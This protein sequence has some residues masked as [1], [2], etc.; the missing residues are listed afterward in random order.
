MSPT[1]R[2][3]CS[4]CPTDLIEPGRARDAGGVAARRGP[5][6]CRCR[7]ASAYRTSSATRRGSALVDWRPA[8]HAS[9]RS[10]TTST[11]TS[12]F[13]PGLQ[14]L[15][16]RRRGLSRRSGGLS[17]LRAPGHHFLPSAEHSRSL[18][19]RLHP[20]HRAC[21]TPSEPMDFAAWFEAYLDGR[22]HTFDARNNTTPRRARDRRQRPGRRRCRPDH[23]IRPAHPHDV[24]G[25]GRRRRIEQALRA[26]GYCNR[27][28]P[29]ARGDHG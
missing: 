18:C 17:R 1:R 27:D 8:G 12:Q 3:W 20:Q 19:V 14:P 29:R 15:D 24:R 2:R 23:L 11:P 10:S 7:A 4:R 28:R 22:W 16:D 6:L 13:V 9:R 25:Q 26:Q 5:E 21:R